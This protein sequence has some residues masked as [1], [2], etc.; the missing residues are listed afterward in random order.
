MIYTSSVGGYVGTFGASGQTTTIRTTWREHVDGKKLV[1]L[2]NIFKRKPI[3]NLDYLEEIFQNEV[4]MLDVEGVFRSKSK[5]VYTLTDY[6]SGKAVYHSPSRD[7][8]FASMKASAALPFVHP[9]VKSKWK[10]L[11]RWRIGGLFSS[12]KSY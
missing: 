7:D 4:S 11:L 3:L 8:L 12:S 10:A 1:D 6:S 9:P 5:L 2:S